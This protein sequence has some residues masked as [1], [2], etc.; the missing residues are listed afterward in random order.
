MTGY[1]LDQVLGKNC[2]FLQGPGTDP[3]QVDALR[4]G[5]SLGVDTS[6]CLM[7]YKADGTSFYNQ[8]FLAALRDNNHKIVNY[9]GVQVEVEVMTIIIIILL[10][11]I[12]NDLLIY[13]G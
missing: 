6:V 5:I 10:K 11:S 2:R 9:V 4:K 12:F 1:R 7:N 13:I 3:R 8:I